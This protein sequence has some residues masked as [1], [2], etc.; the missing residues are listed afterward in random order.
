MVQYAEL[1]S[2]GEGADADEDEEL[3]ADAQDPKFAVAQN[4]YAVA[5]C[6]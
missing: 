6:R 2:E 3:F 5:S 1:L 4:G